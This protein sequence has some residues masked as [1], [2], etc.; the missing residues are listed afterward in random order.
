MPWLRPPTLGQSNA[1][2]EVG[3]LFVNGAHT[4]AGAALVAG[5]RLGGGPALFFEWASDD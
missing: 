4:K 2:L 3:H 5:S 1:E